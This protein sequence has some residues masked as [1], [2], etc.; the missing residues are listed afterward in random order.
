MRGGGT[1]A[2][3]VPQWH[4]TFSASADPATATIYARGTLEL[5]TV[6]YLRGEVERLRGQGVRELRL[7][8]RELSSIDRTAANYVHRLATELAETGGC[9]HLVDCRE[10]VRSHLQD[11]L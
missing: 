6:E 3:G 10:P 8:L 9:L 7:D 2:G 5:F 11:L 1:S 4:A